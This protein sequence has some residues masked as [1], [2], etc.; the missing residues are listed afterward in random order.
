MQLQGH[1]GASID[2]LCI[3]N[4]IYTNRFIYQEQYLL[5]SKYPY[6]RI[7]QTVYQLEG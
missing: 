3:K 5:F 4:R 6:G 1:T 2:F 7:T